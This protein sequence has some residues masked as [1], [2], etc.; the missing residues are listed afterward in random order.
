M[1]RYFEHMKTQSTHDRR[2]HAMRIAS[3]MTAGM[4]AVWITTLGVGFATPNVN[5]K[6][7]TNDPDNQSQTAS[8]GNVQQDSL[9]GNTLEVAT[10][11]SYDST[12]IISNIQ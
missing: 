1:K 3:V 2:Q 7:A 6:T 4:F 9:K 10:T 12:T 11:T 8:V 5:T